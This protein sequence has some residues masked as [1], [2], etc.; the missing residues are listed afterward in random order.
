MKK[1]VGYRFSAVRTASK[2]MEKKLLKNVEKLYS[3]PRIVIPR[4]ED[5][6]SEKAFKK[7]LKQLEK[8]DSIKDDVGKLERLSKK[9]S[10][11][12]AVAGTLLIAHTKKAPFLAVT[13][14]PIGDITYA[15][16]G[17]A[18]PEYL[19]AVQHL[20]NPI[21]RLLGVKDIAMKHRLHIYSWDE[22]FISTG[23]EASPPKDFKKFVLRTLSL[24]VQT[25]NHVMSCQ[26]ISRDKVENNMRDKKPYL[27]I[28]WKSADVTIALCENCARRTGNTVYSIT[29]YLIE[30]D[31][32]DDFDVKVVGC[33]VKDKSIDETKFLD[34][35]LSGALSDYELINRNM[36]EREKTLRE[37][38]GREF[39]LDGVSFGDDFERF[40]EA[41]NPKIYEREALDYI[42]SRVD[43]PIIVN[44]T[45]PNKVLEELWEEY[46]REVIS[47]I[48]RDED[49][50]DEFLSLEGSPSDILKTAWEYREQ[51][52]ILSKLPKYKD[53]P[54][55]VEFVD[56]IAKKYRLFGGEK[57]LAE[58]L[59]PPRSTKGKSLSY[60]FLLVLGK[61][62]DQKWRFSRV[63]IESGEFLRKYAEELLVSPPEG[64]HKALKNL[65]MAAGISED[66]DKYLV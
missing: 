52:E 3:N 27:S 63:E 6:H 56:R 25:S 61:G 57:V 19:M 28:R 8:I 46:G 40:I 34:E 18:S 36:K 65:L 66:L 15:K 33:I 12:G 50:I 60:A 13:K 7:V 29:K 14:L 39:I 37:E 11:A 38:R 23:V 20:D 35:Y 54:P 21:L 64:Y 9:N 45:T 59:D 42:L 1:K 62:V 44:K 48:I 31:V 51:R 16:R 4:F 32:E 22:G 30:P 2:S 24:P 53:L 10:L 47:M 58:L 43:H 5:S 55:T 49:L 17:K 41:L 26:H